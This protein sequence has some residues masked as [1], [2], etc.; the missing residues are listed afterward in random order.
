MQRFLVFFLVVG[1]VWAQPSTETCADG[2]VIARSPFNPNPCE[3][4]ERATPGGSSATV[5]E[6]VE[7]AAASAPNEFLLVYGPPPTEGS[8]RGRI[9]R[10]KS[11]QD[12]RHFRGLM[13]EPVGFER[14]ADFY[15]RWAS[16]ARSSTR[17]VTATTAAGRTPRTAR[18]KRPCLPQSTEQ[19]SSSPP[20][21]RGQSW[22][23]TS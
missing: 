7:A 5:D 12:L 4:F 19:A 13:P 3:A 6:Q 23:G 17:A 15:A 2:R 11:E 18:R 21:K 1:A 9:A 14:I 20:G 22:K 8:F 10:V 16:A